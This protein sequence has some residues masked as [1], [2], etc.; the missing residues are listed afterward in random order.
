MATPNFQKRNAEPRGRLRSNDWN[1]MQDEL[2]GDVQYLYD[3]VSSLDANLARVHRTLSLTALNERAMTERIQEEEANRRFQQAT[4]GGPVWEYIGFRS[5][6]NLLYEHPTNPALW[7]IAAG[8][9]LRAEPGYG[10]VTL[11]YDRVVSRFYSV[12]PDRRKIVPVADVSA[13]ITAVTSEDGVIKVINGDVQYAFNGQNEKSWTRETW[14]PLQSDV[15]EVTVDLDITIPVSL[16]TTSNVLQVHMDPDGLQ[17]LISVSYDTANID[18]TLDLTDTATT[19]WNGPA[20]PVNEASWV[21]GHFTPLSI[22]RMKLRIRQ[23]N[24]VERD[25]FKVFTLGLQ[26]VGLLLVEFDNDDTNLVASN[27][28]N[29]KSVVVRLD[30]PASHYIRSVSGIWSDPVVGSDVVLAVYADQALTDKRWDSTEPLPQSTTP[31]LMPA[32]TT[33]IYVAVGLGFDQANNV[34]TIL[35]DLTIRYEVT[36]V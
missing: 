32:Q 15:E 33:A 20:L 13:T 34:A 14:Y 11:P 3:T 31:V 26:E 27:P 29:D 35:N 28:T 22:Q 17:D 8:K 16:A 25:G 30:T 4:G 24:W 36:E 5:K 1:A 23:R 7:S 12:N 6:Q 21:R 2:E 19:K 18:P 10:Q 9:R